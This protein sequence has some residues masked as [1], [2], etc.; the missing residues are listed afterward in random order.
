MRKRKIPETKSIPHAKSSSL[1]SADQRIPIEYRRR[2]APM[3]MSP[4]LNIQG[5]TALGEPKSL[6]ASLKKSHQGLLE[7]ARYT[8][9]AN[10]Q[11]LRGPRRRRVF[12]RANKGL[13]LIR[14]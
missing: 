4:A 1:L 5:F 7:A 8:V 13:L 3:I 9:T 6:N 14:V 10:M 12:L 11:K 2:M